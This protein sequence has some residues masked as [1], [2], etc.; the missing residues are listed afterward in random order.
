MVRHTPIH[1]LCRRHRIPYSLCQSMQSTRLSTTCTYVIQDFIPFIVKLCSSYIL[2][3]SSLS[4]PF[5]H[6]A[7]SLITSPPLITNFPRYALF[8]SSHTLFNQGFEML[9][10]QDN[11]G[12]V[13]ILRALMLC[14]L[15]LC[16]PMLYN[17]MLQSPLLYG[18]MLCV[19]TLCSPLLCDPMLC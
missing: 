10:S 19:L 16:N 2:A 14:G 3:S 6:H 5:S 7:P 15:M 9:V 13:H 11:R 4:L 18:L 8:S 1:L 17:S 12:A